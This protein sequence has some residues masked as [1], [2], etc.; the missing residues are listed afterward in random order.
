MTGKTEY[1]TTVHFKANERLIGNIVPVLMK[2]HKGFYYM[3][4]IVLQ[5]EK[6]VD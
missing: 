3:G 2:E 4:E 1:G 6:E 5:N